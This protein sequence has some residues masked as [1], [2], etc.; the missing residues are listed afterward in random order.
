MQLSRRIA[1]SL[2]SSASQS[3]KWENLWRSPLLQS[4]MSTDSPRKT[5]SRKS[6]KAL[7]SNPRVSD[8]VEKS[9]SLEDDYLQVS[10]DP[11]DDI[12]VS[13]VEDDPV[14]SVSDARELPKPGKIPWQTKAANSVNLIGYLGGPIQ[15]GVSS[16][17]ISTAVSILINKKTL[18]LPQ[19]W[20]VIFSI[21]HIFVKIS[22]LS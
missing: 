8:S 16:N 15:L 18:D 6:T 17:G 7:S 5:S 12:S 2:S 10:V 4:S 1:G 13:P 19:L 21:L 11:A 14:K 20:S 22:L 9:T 3:K